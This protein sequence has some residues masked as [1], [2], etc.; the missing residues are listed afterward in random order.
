MNIPTDTQFVCYFR[1]STDGQ[2]LRGLGMDAQRAAVA[3][4]LNGRQPLREFAEVESGKRVD[5]P[6]LRAALDLCR[7]TGATLLIAKL[8]R[9]ARNAAFMLSLRDS[10]VEFKAADMPD[11]SRFVVGIMALVAEQERDA[12]S[13]R[14]KKALA[15]ARLRGRVGGNPNPAAAAALGRAARAR[16]AAESRSLLLPIIREI[17]DVGRVGTL[18]GIANAL[19]ARGVKPVGGGAWWPSGVANVLKGEVVVA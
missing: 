11:A 4:F 13:D 18:R 12:T 1:V 14:T 17:R 15:A 10:G 9:L 6:Q 16:L 5:R 8:D 7:D 2:G 19:N 3:G